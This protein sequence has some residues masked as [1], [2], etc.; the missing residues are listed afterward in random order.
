MTEQVAVYP[1]KPLPPQ[2]V[3]ILRLDGFGHV[4]TPNVRLH[5]EVLVGRLETISLEDIKRNHE[6]YFALSYCWQRGEYVKELD[7][8]DC[9]IWC[10]YHLVQLQPN[11]HSALWHLAKQEDGPRAIW[12]DALCVDQS[13][14]Q[15][16]GEQVSIMGDIY[17]SV[18]C[19]IAWLGPEG[20]KVEYLFAALTLYARESPPPDHSEWETIVSSKD[21]SGES[22][23]PSEGELDQAGNSLLDFDFNF[24]T[25]LPNPRDRKGLTFRRLKNWLKR[26]GSLRIT[27]ATF[28]RSLFQRRERQAHWDFGIKPD[29]LKSDR[30][31]VQ[32][33]LTFVRHCGWF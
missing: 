33:G 28:W 8:K 12:A 15:E 31:K 32:D 9:H 24:N 16:K 13:N 4:D 23:T 29:Y 17:G 20:E 22:V 25:V 18:G 26:R 30:D 14:I 6:E 1:Y 5:G 19:V 10:D 7:T 21:D 11:L 3:R 2:H 27:L